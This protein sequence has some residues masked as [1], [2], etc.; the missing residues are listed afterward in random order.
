GEDAHAEERLALPT[1]ARGVVLAQR[2]QPQPIGRPLSHVLLASPVP[3][4][5]ILVLGLEETALP[6]ELLAEPVPH[7]VLGAWRDRQEQDL[8]VDVRRLPLGAAGP[9]GIR[10]EEERRWDEGITRG[11]R[12]QL[13][14]GARRPGGVAECQVSS[15]EARLDLGAQLG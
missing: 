15:D 10:D 1:R 11:L 12:L 4:L 5:P 2:H 8:S 7:V 13:A 3:Q 14:R 9:R 6:L